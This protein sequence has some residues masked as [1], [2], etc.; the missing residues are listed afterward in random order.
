MLHDENIY[1]DPFKFIPERFMKD[2]QLNL[3][4]RD[5]SNAS[6]GFGRR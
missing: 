5:P 1:P 2:G 6:W 4:V 3:D